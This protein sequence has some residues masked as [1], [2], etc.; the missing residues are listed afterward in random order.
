MG[1]ENFKTLCLAALL[2]FPLASAG[3]GSLD[4]ISQLCKHV[5]FPC[6]RECHLLPLEKYEPSP[7][8]REICENSADTPAD[9]PRQSLRRELLSAV[10]KNWQPPALETT[11][12]HSEPPPAPEDLSDRITSTIIPHVRFLNTPLPHAI[13]A[14]ASIAEKNVTSGGAVNF[15]LLGCDAAA[16]GI[17]VNLNLKNISLYRLIELVAQSANFQFDIGKD[18]V[19]FYRCHTADDT[20][21]TEIFPM[22]RGTLVRLTGCH[23]KRDTSENPTRHPEDDERG[24]REF[25]ERAGINF[26]SL[27]G[28]T[29]AF[30]GS[31]IIVT[32]TCRNLKKISNILKKYSQVKQVEIE[33]KFLE[34]QQ[35]VLEELGMRWQ[36]NFGSGAVLQTGRE[37]GGANADNLRSLRQAFGSGNFSRGDG[38]IVT[39]G[40]PAEQIGIPNAAPGQPGQINLGYSG[41][42]LGNITGV[43]NKF[44]CNLLINALEQQAGSDLMSAPKVTVLSGKTAE[45]VVAME[46]RYPQKYGD[47]HSEVGVGSGGIGLNGSSAGVTITAGTPQDFTTRNVGVEMSVRPIVESD[48]SISLQLDPKVTEFEGFVEYGGVSIATNAQATI[49][50]PSGFYQPIFSTREIHTEVNIFD[51]ATVVMGGLTREEVKEVH[52]RVP[53][54]GSIPLIGRLF[55]SKSEST[56]KRNL[57][58][59]VTAHTISPAG[60]KVSRT[61]PEED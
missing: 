46:L 44:Q 21:E 13:E 12:P 35:G 34:V 1:M 26:S 32:N 52:D 59:F 29:L 14:L 61:P 51:G 27:P 47:T 55:Q 2:L 45:I 5:V 60:E 31:Q 58:I 41:V 6:E 9:L 43:I 8:A 20:L 3:A 36:V 54:L 37:M 18:A 56:Q 50:V 33:A 11:I 42:P 38:K 24:I 16:H 7:P 25:F 57:L 48:G 53:F 4:N 23:S 28:S 17:T 30:D 22:S 49:S 19:I 10:D 39:F 40:P 15:V